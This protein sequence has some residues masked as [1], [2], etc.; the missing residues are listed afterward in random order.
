[1]SAVTFLPASAASASAATI[2][3][4]ETLT[5][6]QLI[7][8]VTVLV[9]AAAIV[10]LIENGQPKPSSTPHVHAST[11]AAEKALRSSDLGGRRPR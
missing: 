10:A 11:G 4:G 9:G 1:M 6:L 8:A 7:G 2:G 3:L 5:P